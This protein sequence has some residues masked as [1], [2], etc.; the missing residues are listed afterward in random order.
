VIATTLQELESL[1]N[2]TLDVAKPLSFEQMSV[3][4]LFN[5]LAPTH[6]YVF[7]QRNIGRKSE[8]GVARTISL[9]M[10]FRTSQR[11]ML[12]GSRL[13]PILLDCYLVSGYDDIVSEVTWAKRITVRHVAKGNR[14]I[15]LRFGPGYKLD[16]IDDSWTLK[17]L[18][19][20]KV[21]LSE[22]TLQDRGWQFNL[23]QHV[24]SAQP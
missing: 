10:V 9:Q 16:R 8:F 23:F 11:S 22:K 18:L 6:G 4:S 5:E 15:N 13:I 17:P 3:A 21:K 7:Q 12:L 24:L 14:E 2:G 1:R 19:R 20:R